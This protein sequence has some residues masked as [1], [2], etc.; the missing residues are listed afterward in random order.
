[1]TP[2]SVTSHVFRNEPVIFA[3]MTGKISK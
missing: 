3:A 2:I 1:M